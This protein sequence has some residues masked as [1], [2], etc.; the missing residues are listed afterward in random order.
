MRTI[1][2]LTITEAA[3]M[4]Q[5]SVRAIERMHN[6]GLLKSVSLDGEYYV[7]ASDLR[8]VAGYAIDN[9]RYLSCECLDGPCDC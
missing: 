8:R 4:Y 6:E 7:I 5:I 2:I 3:E 1:D 9:P